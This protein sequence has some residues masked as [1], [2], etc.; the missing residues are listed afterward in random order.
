[1]NIER[2]LAVFEENN[3]YDLLM[4]CVDIINEHS[5]MFSVLGKE[6]NRQ[7]QILQEL[8]KQNQLLLKNI[9]VMNAHIKII[10]Q[11]LANL[12]GQKQNEN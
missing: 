1:V 12:E 5:E 2:G 7:E 10:N 6:M 9:R 8:V 11:R 4:R 3:P